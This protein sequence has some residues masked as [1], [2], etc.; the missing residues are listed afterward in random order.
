MM[1]KCF[2]LQFTPSG[3]VQKITLLLTSCLIEHVNS[4]FK[5]ASGRM[6]TSFTEDTFIHFFFFGGCIQSAF[7]VSGEFI[8]LVN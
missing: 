7:V 8:N 6:K 4:L 5:T 2:F 3:T 1:N